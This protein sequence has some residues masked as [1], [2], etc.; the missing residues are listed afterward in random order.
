[1]DI[2]VTS[3]AGMDMATI[4]GKRKD[5]LIIILND[6]QMSICKNV[7]GLATYLNKLRM[8][9]GYNKLKSDI[10]STLDTT[11]FGKRVKNSLSKLKDG[12]KKLLYQVCTLKILD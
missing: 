11:S 9:V 12:I 1:M 4:L 6:N 10:G 5:N 7:G 8:G 2:R 3:S